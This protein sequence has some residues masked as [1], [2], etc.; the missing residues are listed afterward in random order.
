MPGKHEVIDDQR[1][2]VAGEELGQ[3]DLGR[4][5]GAIEAVEDIVLW[6]LAA[7]RQGTAGRRDGFHGAPERDLF[8]EQAQSCAAI[9]VGFVWEGAGHRFGPSFSIQNLR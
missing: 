9:V 4:F 7:G 8:I 2:G 1:A 3:P 5:P 6:D